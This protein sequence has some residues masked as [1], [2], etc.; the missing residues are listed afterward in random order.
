MLLERD[1]EL[2]ALRAAVGQGGPGLVVV[3]G[4]AGIGKTR[5]LAE[6]RR[7]V[8]PRVLAARGGE[9]EQGLAFGVVRQLFETA[10]SA[11]ALEGAAREVFEGPASGVAVASWMAGITSGRKSSISCRRT[12]M[13]C[14]PSRFRVR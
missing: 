4:P 8:E 13:R 9:L 5:L 12:W 14:V 6:V 1:G 10:I 7:D 2:T 11:A 3:E